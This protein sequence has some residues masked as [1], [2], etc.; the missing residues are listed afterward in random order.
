MFFL[1]NSFL[2]ETKWSIM[3]YFSFE[4]EANSSFVTFILKM[5]SPDLVLWFRHDSHGHC[6]LYIPAKIF[7]I[8]KCYLWLYWFW[9]RGLWLFFVTN[10]IL[11]LAEITSI[12]QNL[13]G[14]KTIRLVTGSN[15]CS[16][17]FFLIPFTSN[18]FFIYCVLLFIKLY[19]F[20]VSYSCLPPW[21]VVMFMPWWE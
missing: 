8:W 17:W 1:N 14:V 19:M 15:F 12:T 3:S 2:H 10:L 6:I 5:L 20:F 4:L 11:L 21:H 18:V 9:N 13:I 16:L 7:K